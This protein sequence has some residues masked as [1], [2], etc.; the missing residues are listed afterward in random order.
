MSEHNAYDERA[1]DYI[2]DWGQSLSR[3]GVL[4]KVGNLLL[5]T[6]GIA[7]VPV[8]PL[9][10]V[11]EAQGFVAG[12][13]DWRMCGIVGWFCQNCCGDVGSYWNCPSCTQW[14][15]TAWRACCYNP[16]ACPDHRWIYYFD[17]CTPNRPDAIACQGSSCHGNP[18]APS[19]C[20]PSQGYYSCTVIAEGDFCS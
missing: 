6:V 3:R 8:L 12:C 7:I 5:R 14:S 15:P 2:A 1:A 17:C 11:V 9:N 20:T 10:R 18:D 16:S 19:Y 4:A 13:S